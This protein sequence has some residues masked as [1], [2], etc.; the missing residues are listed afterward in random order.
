M[1]TGDFPEEPP[2]E[3]QNETDSE[4]LQV[5]ALP[6]Y[7]DSESVII[8]VQYTDVY[9]LI[10]DETKISISQLLEECS[11]VELQS[12]SLIRIFYEGCSLD[13]W[14]GHRKQYTVKLGYS[15]T[16]LNKDI[17]QNQTCPSSTSGSVQVPAVKC[18]SA[19]M[20]VTLAAKE[21]KEARFVDLNAS[22]LREKVMTEENGLTQWTDGENLVIQVENPMKEP[23]NTTPVGTTATSSGGMPTTVQP[24]HH[25]QELQPPVHHQQPVTMLL[26]LQ[27]PLQWVQL[28][29]HLE[30][31]GTTAT[32][33]GGVP[34]T[35][36]SAPSN[37]ASTPG[38]NAP[39]G[40]TTTSS[41]GVPA[42]SSSS[43]STDVISSPGNITPVG[44]TT[45]SSGGIPTTTSSSATSNA[46]ASPGNTTP[47][48]L[49]TVS[50]AGASTSTASSGTSSAAS[51]TPGNITP[52]VT[53]IPSY[54]GAST[55]TVSSATSN[56]ASTP[57]YTIPLVITTTSTAT[58][59][60]AA[61][62]P[63]NT[64]PIVPTTTSSGGVP[65]TVSP[66]PSSNAVSA[67][68]LGTSISN[69]GISNMTPQT[70]PVGTQST[71]GASTGVPT[72]T[73]STTVTTETTAVA[74]STTNRI[75][76]GIG[77][78][79]E[80]TTFEPSTTDNLQFAI[81]LPDSFWGFP[82]FPSYSY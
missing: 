42:P 28:L 26:L 20:T 32:S 52:V 37:A 73:S 50:S 39:L 51:T 82:T 41:G 66:L 38:N 63:A 34:T 19:N 68:G 74:T 64:N 61:S 14:F 27:I 69:T 59:N 30:A 78:N 58:S 46:A 1:N 49:P 56:A 55:T 79:G 57:G 48:A 24:L 76:P 80:T 21:L 4:E 17:I 6:F 9:L 40:T 23:G 22:T 77:C 7:C 2:Q 31:L 5:S 65:T 13:N 35:S 25:L 81:T 16:T 72:S 12:N 70:T 43:A 67:P 47:V 53:T 18:E 11:H 29:H 44:S 71:V 75:T 45:T 62:N 36:S 15:N 10:D 60:T 33:S 8:G 54:A 3:L